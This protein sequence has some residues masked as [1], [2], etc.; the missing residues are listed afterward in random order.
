MVA[1]DLSTGVQGWSLRSDRRRLAQHRW[2]PTM[3][4]RQP[5]EVQHADLTGNY[6]S[7]AGCVLRAFGGFG[8]ILRKADKSSGSHRGSFLEG[9]V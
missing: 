2:G 8:F 5:Q 1:C 9:Y 6:S 4:A 7:Q 3:S